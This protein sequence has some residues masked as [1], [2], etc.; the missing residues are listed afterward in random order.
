MELLEKE[1]FDLEVQT[2]VEEL[3]KIHGQVTPLV[4][5]NPDGGHIVGYL[6]QLP[7]DAKLRIMDSTLT[8][9]Y[10]ACDML[11]NHYMIEGESDPR[12]LKEDVY[13]MGA[14]QELYAQVKM[15]VN[16]FKKK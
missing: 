14:I 1:K 13:R 16:Q 2:K 10:S 12:I 6:K 5:I 4:F 7:F 11:L 8:G 9:A 3:S 15:S